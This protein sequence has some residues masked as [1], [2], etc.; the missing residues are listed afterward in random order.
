ME[1]TLNFVLVATD[2]VA[3]CEQIMEKAAEQRSRFLFSL[4]PLNM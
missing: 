3:C 1:A 2:L 4:L